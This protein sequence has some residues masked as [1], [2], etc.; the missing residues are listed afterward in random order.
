[1]ADISSKQFGLIVAHVLPGFIGLAGITP[2][3]PAVAQWLQPVSQGDMGFGP[4]IYALMAATTVGMIVGCVRWLVVDHL[5]EWSGVPKMVRR[6]ESLPDKL[7]ALDHLIE[8]HYRYYQFYANTLVAILWAYG[9][10]RFYGTLPLLGPGTDLGVLILGAVLL[11]GSRDTLT[12]YR[13]RLGRVLGPVA[14]K[15]LK[16]EVMTNG[17]DHHAGGASKPT[18]ES[19]PQTAAAKPEQPE[20]RQADKAQ[21]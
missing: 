15:G 20:P 3:F 21:K 16:G 8:M 4:P 18:T 13:Q 7:D 10:N 17:A 1:M 5:L 14:E 11:A 2:L 12:K 9:M 6:Y 19:K